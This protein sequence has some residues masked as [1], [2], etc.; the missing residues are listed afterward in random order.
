MTALNTLLSSFPHS[1]GILK[2]RYITVQA[3]AEVTGYNAQY[4]H[5]LLR[6]H[7]LEGVKVG[8][9]WLIR[10]T[11]LG[12]YLKSTE[13]TS[14]QRCGPKGMPLYTPVNSDCLQ[15]CTPIETEV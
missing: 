3:T 11:S 14:D 8:Q 9:V 12:S 13:H 2:E 6:D 1:T 4:L 7:Q 15:M 10:M 5:R